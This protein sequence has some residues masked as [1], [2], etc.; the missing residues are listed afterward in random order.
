M[1]SL[2]RSEE[3]DLLQIRLNSW[4]TQSIEEQM[5]CNWEV[6]QLF[7]DLKNAYTSVMIKCGIAIR[8]YRQINCAG[9]KCD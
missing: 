8:I 7:T 5:A 9:D 3:I 1:Y 6:Y 4:Q 2:C